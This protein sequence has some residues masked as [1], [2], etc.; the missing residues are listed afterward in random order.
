M[1]LNKWSLVGIIIL[2]LCI[3]GGISFPDIVFLFIF[4]SIIGLVILILANQDFL[5]EFYVN[6]QKQ[7]NIFQIVIDKIAGLAVNGDEL[8]NA[9]K[10]LFK[11]KNNFWDPVEKLNIETIRKNAAEVEV[12]IEK[13]KKDPSQ[14]N[15]HLSMIVML[16]ILV[17]SVIIYIFFVTNLLFIKSGIQIPIIIISIFVTLFIAIKAYY[18]LLTKD[19]IKLEIAKKKGWI[20]NPNHDNEKYQN[21][22]KYFPET[23]SKGNQNKYIEDQ[24]WGLTT[25]NNKYIYFYTGLFYYEIVT[26]SGK[27]RHV[28]KYTTHYFIFPLKKDINARFHLYPENGVSSFLNLFT[29]KEINVESNKFNKMFAFTYDGE[30]GEKAQEIVKTITPVMQEKLIKLYTQKGYSEILF[31]RTA[32]VFLFSK[33]IINNIRTDFNKSAEINTDDLKE[34]DDKLTELIIISEEIS[35]YLD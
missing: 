32:V 9:E 16:G 27:N 14:V 35:K 29:K 17:C 2:I 24:F 7:I 1:K 26:G 19:L 4:L 33:D 21:L 15:R 22:L 3:I 8:L 30:K 5:T 18:I 6:P 13:L 34:I 28:E 12:K 20:Y 10:N 23:F 11:E 25:I 31:A